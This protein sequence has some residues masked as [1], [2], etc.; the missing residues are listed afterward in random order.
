MPVT[1]SGNTIISS[2][3]S[4]E[5]DKTRRCMIDL[6]AVSAIA[7]RRQMSHA[8]AA[9]LLTAG[10]EDRDGRVNA[11]T[12]IGPGKVLDAR[13]H[14]GDKRTVQRL[15]KAKQV[16]AIFWDERKDLTKTSAKV[17]TKATT[18]DGEEDCLLYTSPSPR[19]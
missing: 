19:D 7:S 14:Y 12:T 3:L 4:L 13:R 17:T 8:D 18:S 16:A 11:K 6:E 2:Q 15:V 1:K 10:N 5:D 9:L